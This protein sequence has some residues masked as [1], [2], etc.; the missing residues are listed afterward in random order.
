MVG[1]A[2]IAALLS[3]NGDSDLIARLKRR[4]PDAM[5]DLYDR[6]GKVT[7]ALIAHIVKNRTVAEDLLAGTFIKVWNRST[8]FPNDSVSTGLWI[9]SMARNHALEYLR[10]G[11][12][13]EAL[14]RPHLFQNFGSVDHNLGRVREAG[15]AFTNLAGHEQR[16]LELAWFEG[17]NQSEIAARMQQPVSAIKTSLDAAIGKLRSR[18][19]P[20]P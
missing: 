3:E 14:E 13:L 4:D 9:L 20:E 12:A 5:G 15:R 7:F 17:L 6:F 2:S 8:S 16:I 18:F 11:A 19:S 10:S 1:L